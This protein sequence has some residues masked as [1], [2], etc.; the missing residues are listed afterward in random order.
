[1]LL[2]YCYGCNVSSRNSDGL[3]NLS[4]ICIFATALVSLVNS[5]FRI[6]LRLVS[7]HEDGHFKVVMCTVC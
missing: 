6:H 1:M 2:L 5:Y 4:H 7:I 3:L